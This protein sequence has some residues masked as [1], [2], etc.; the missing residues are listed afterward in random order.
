M[1]RTWPK[2]KADGHAA[3]VLQALG[4]ERAARSS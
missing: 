4:E 3:E 2:V 1:A